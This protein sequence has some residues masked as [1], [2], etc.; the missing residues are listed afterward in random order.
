MLTVHTK[1]LKKLIDFCYSTNHT[2]LRVTNSSTVN[3]PY[4]AFGA[5]SIRALFAI[6]YAKFRARVQYFLGFQ[7]PAHQQFLDN[8]MMVNILKI[9]GRKSTFSILP[10][11]A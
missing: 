1:V 2:G 10:T 8:R 5:W 7:L 6:L 9:S 4:N 11:A 3:D